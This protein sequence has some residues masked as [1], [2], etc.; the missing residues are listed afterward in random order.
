LITSLRLST[1][2]FRRTPPISELAVNKVIKETFIKS[3]IM[4]KT[5]SIILAATSN[6]TRAFD[7]R[8]DVTEDIITTEEWTSLSTAT[9]TCA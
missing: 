9:C 4:H 3:Y 5:L 1:R 6:N 7:Q 8:N 2:S